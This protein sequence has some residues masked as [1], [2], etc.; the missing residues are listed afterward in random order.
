VSFED[1]RASWL[2]SITAD[3]QGRF[4]SD[5]GLIVFDQFLAFRQQS[6]GSCKCGA[7]LP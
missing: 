2:E 7:Y 3:N 6:A 1:F 5:N 4:S